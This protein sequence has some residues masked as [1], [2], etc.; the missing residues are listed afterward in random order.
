MNAEIK[1]VMIPI[2]NKARGFVPAEAPVGLSNWNHDAMNR[3]EG[4]NYRPFPLFN[5][6]PMRS[7]IIY[8]GTIGSA[9][10]V[11]FATAY[12]IANTSAAGAIYETAGRG[13]VSSRKPNKSLNPKAREHFLGALPPLYDSSGS[14]TRKT[15]GRLIFRAW[16][17]NQGKATA[18]ANKAIDTAVRQFNARRTNAR[19]AV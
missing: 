1:A 13:E 16:A 7:G 3:S 4:V 5:A 9:S 15:K 2:R 10:K 8:S 12:Y 14:N 6:S 17:E 11:G 19:Q 18:A